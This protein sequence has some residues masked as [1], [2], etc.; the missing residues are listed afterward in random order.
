M[1]HSKTIHFGTDASNSLLD[2]V[3][4]LA[5]VVKVTMGPKGRNVMIQRQ[6]GT[7]HIT[8]DGVSV[9]KEVFLENNVED[10]GAQIVK[11]V[12]A[13]TAE[14]AG[15]GTTTATVLAHAIFK[16]GF[17]YVVAG[18]N[19]VEIKR[20]MDKTTESLI[21]QLKLSSREVKSKKEIEQVGMISANGDISIGSMLASAMD[22][23]GLDGVITVE[24]AKGLE[25]S[26]EVIEGMKFDKGYLSKEFITNQERM[27]CELI[28]PLIFMTENIIGA[29]KDIVKVL[30]QA[31]QTGRPLL[32][33]V[34]D[35]L[36]DA[37]NTLVLNK[38]NG[39]LNV[40][41]IKAP[42]FGGRKEDYL[43]DMAT[44]TGGDVF[45]SEGLK[46]S[47]ATLENLGEASKVNITK[48]ET[49][50]IG[51]KGDT[52]EIDKLVSVIKGQIEVAEDDYE[53][54]KLKDRL[55]KLTGGIA[56][57]KIGATTEAELLEKKDRVDDAL[58]ATTAAVEEGVVI[59]GGVALIEAGMKESKADFDLKG[60]E[61]FGRKIV[62]KA[63]QAPLRQIVQNCG[64]DSGYVLGNILT[65]EDGMGYNASTGEFVDMF[66]AGIIDPLKVTR[67]ALKN[68]VSVAGMLLTTNAVIGFTKE[69]I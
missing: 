21:E 16:E 39:V 17:K 2:G 63:I 44:F 4:K 35:I 46:M 6:D 27:T 23:V 30:E 28:N 31:Q 51:G 49:I 52:D 68:A 24:E 26:L 50:I 67:I 47:D 69:E 5:N 64:E 48:N 62:L 65:L 56:V 45:R 3:E 18:A 29:L 61:E 59:G 60:D 9:A 57:I 43:R 8:K 32:L 55:A 41:V 7:S 37:L 20:G 40:T 33:I 54:N 19:P 11:E 58:A 12:S 22:K 1:I 38:L 36:D 34:D 53:K 15:D 42:G 25:D 14:E 66:E 13:N 10:M